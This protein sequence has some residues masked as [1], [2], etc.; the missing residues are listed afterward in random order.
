[1]G[2]PYV[3]QQPSTAFEKKPSS[4]IDAL[5]EHIASHDLDGKPWPD[6]AKYAVSFRVKTWPCG[7]SDSMPVFFEDAAQMR[8][9]IASYESW[10][11]LEDNE[12]SFSAWRWNLGPVYLDSR[13]LD[14]LV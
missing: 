9:W 11:T 13:K 5:E 14:H 1:M 10:A 7:W 2:N 4:V 3:V 8:E 12:F 6:Y